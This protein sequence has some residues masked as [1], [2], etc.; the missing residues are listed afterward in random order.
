MS[1]FSGSIRESAQNDEIHLATSEISFSQILVGTDF[2]KSA[3]Q[4]LALAVTIAEFFDSEIIV[5]HAVKPVIYGDSQEPMPPEVLNAQLE[6]AKY[7]MKELIASDPRL[8]KLRVQTKVDFGRAV[9]LI[10]QVAKTTKSTLI[11]VGSHGAGG[12]KKFTF[13]SVAETILRQSSCPTLIVG[14]QCQVEH[15]PFR[16][17]LFATDLETTG[18]RPAQYAS[19]LAEH[20]DGRLTLL[21]VIEKRPDSPEFDFDLFEDRL[22]KQLRGLLPSDVELFCNPKIRLE[23][24]SPAQ[25]ITSIARSEATSLIIVGAHHQSALAD[26][27]P[28]S[29]L[30]HVIRETRCG[31][32]VV[33]SHLI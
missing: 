2:S 21:H 29:T 10:D 9:D 16:S 20:V 11:V 5:I 19:A 22:R 13:G 3:A 23:Y 14:P 33:R 31:V 8:A 15:H 12:L 7:D 4:A 6:T 27:A 18:L 1:S 30:S 25:L 26:H 32:L 24:G 28:W 17:I